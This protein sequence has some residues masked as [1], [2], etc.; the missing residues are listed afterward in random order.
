MSLDVLAESW[1]SNILPNSRIYLI[2]NELLKLYSKF[3]GINLM[4]LYN[5][6]EVYN[7]FGWFY[8][9]QKS[10]LFQVQLIIDS[11]EL[12][13][14]VSNKEVLEILKTTSYTKLSFYLES[15]KRNQI[16]D[17]RN[18]F[19]SINIY[20]PG[21]NPEYFKLLDFKAEEIPITQYS[22]SISKRKR[23]SDNIENKPKNKRVKFNNDG[24]DIDWKNMVSASSTRNYLLNDPCIDWMK[25]Y[26]IKSIH[27]VPSIKGNTQGDI[28]YVIDDP[29]TKFIMDQGCQF[30]EQVVEL[31]RKN[32]KLVK[33]AESYQSRNKELFQKTIQYM[34]EGI[35]IIYQG[36][37]HDY[38]NKTFGAPDLMIR[39]DYLNKFI[40]YN[41]YNETFGSPKL[42]VNWHYVIVDIKHS[43]INLTADRVHIL[44]SESIPAYKGQLLVYTNALNNIQGTNVKKAFIM[45]KK[46]SYTIQ[47]NTYYIYD[48]MNKLGTIDYNG[49]DKEYVEK[50]VK[51]IEWIQT[52][53]NEGHNWKLLPLPTKEELFP[54]MKN[55]KDGAFGKIKKLLAEEI[56]EITSVY[57][58]GIKN[59]KE[60]FKNGIFGWNDE[61]C[62][63][64]TLGFNEGKIAE[65]VNAI[66]DINRQNI[67]V[68]L[69]KNIKYN[70]SEWRNRK[71]TEME[72][73]LDYET[74]NSN[75]GK[76]H[77][78]KN[79]VDYED[80][81]LIFMIGV[82]YDYNGSWEFKSFI[83]NK[84]TKEGEK[85]ILESFWVFINQKLK[86]AGKTEAVFIHWSQAERT[87]Y[88]KSKL[89]NPTLPEKNMIDLYQVFLN[90]PIVI[91]G[92]L[93]YSLKS[94]AKA[95]YENK[96]IST[97]WDT[98]NSCANGLN[99]MLLAYQV[100]SKNI[101]N[102]TEDF[103]MKEIEKYNE[104]DCKCL[105]EIINYLRKNH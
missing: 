57:Y 78:E 43:Q 33:V 63:S 41:I 35:P 90:E 93:N 82:G 95:L 30:E 23:L 29:F 67:N 44:N 6:N 66:L 25:E 32:H 75:F 55:D 77:I 73:Y 69:P 42:N 8:D 80:F 92:S 58:C 103:T 65:R 15:L 5:L 27:D 48:F 10:R 47:K 68:V 7:T 51:A 17:K 45:G 12:Y 74:M 105:W 26:N 84:N 37:L 94:I 53:R 88:D 3:T 72:F 70:T 96:L 62:N 19:E 85:E 1:S 71:P 102:P 40:G 18:I 59:R 79:H 24:D 46:Y 87:S 60:A 39:N 28:K 98:S 99:A 49:F 36:I 50:L 56:H 89:R 83:A 101:C 2:T 13:S 14:D 100:Y 64:K 104:I 91:K 16:C 76:I 22:T 4:N 52:V 81:N 9:K 20:E 21:K 11:K 54:N 86:E 38:D 97:I 31:I 34:K 61:K